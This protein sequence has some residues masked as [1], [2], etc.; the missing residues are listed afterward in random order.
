MSIELHVLGTEGANLDL[1]RVF[2]AGGRSVFGL[3][4]LAV[5]VAGWC[6][7]VLQMDPNLRVGNAFNR[8]FK[9]GIRT[10]KNQLSIARKKEVRNAFAKSC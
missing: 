2:F 1:S 7:H 8:E 3:P 6:Y 9:H 10:P 4:I 5:L